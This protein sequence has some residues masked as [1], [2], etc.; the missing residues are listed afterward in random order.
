MMKALIAQSAKSL[1]PSEFSHYF[2]KPEKK[3]KPK[4]KQKTKVIK[5]TVY[6]LTK[7]DMNQS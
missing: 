4:P 1:I 6:Q 2:S 5:K 3:K 7:D